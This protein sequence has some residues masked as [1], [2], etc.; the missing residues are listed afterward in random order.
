MK[1]RSNHRRCSVKDMFL[2]I[3]QNSQGNTCARDSFLI[4]LLPA[5]L[6]KKTLRHS[7]FP[8]NFEKF[9]RTPFLRNTSRRLLLEVFVIKSCYPQ[10]FYIKSWKFSSSSFSILILLYPIYFPLSYSTWPFI[11]RLLGHFHLA[12]Y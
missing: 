2:E 5:T 8:V 4:K 7:C 6:L 10:L 3:S 11:G 1:F 12:V 9:L